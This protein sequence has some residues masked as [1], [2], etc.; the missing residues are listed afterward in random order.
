MKKNNIL[1]RP[2]KLKFKVPK[3]LLKTYYSKKKLSTLQISRKLGIKSR[4][5]VRQ[6]M[7]EFGIPRRTRLDAITKYQ[8]TQFSGKD[9]EKAYLIGLR[10]GDVSCIANHNQIRVSTTTTHPAQINMM[11]NVFGKYSHVHAYSFDNN[12]QTQIHVYSDL[13]KSFNFLL[14]KVQ[15]IPSWIMKNDLYFFSFLAGFA[16]SEGCWCIAKSDEWFNFVFTLSNTNA[17]ILEQ[18]KMRLVGFGLTPRIRQSKEKGSLDGFGVRNE[19]LHVLHIENKKFVLKLGVLL[20]LLIH[21]GEKARKIKLMLKLRDKIR[22]NEIKNS[23][24]KLR[25]G[26]KTEVKTLQTAP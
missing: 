3:E 11:K 23:V 18:I 16:D 7:I 5:T 19:A 20:L 21:H 13:D 15:K 2:P 26:I 6:R 12:G 14:G 17:T 9:D 24:L 25:L 4:E 10:A 1:L 22:W 8:K